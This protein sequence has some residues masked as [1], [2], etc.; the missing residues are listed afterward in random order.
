MQDARLLDVAVFQFPQGYRFKDKDE[1][2]NYYGRIKIRKGSTQDP[3]ANLQQDGSEPQRLSDE[4]KKLLNDALRKIADMGL[5]TLDEIRNNPAK[6]L[7]LMEAFKKAKQ[8]VT[9]AA[10]RAIPV[11]DPDTGQMTAFDQF[12]RKAV[13][14]M[15]LGPVGGIFKDDPIAATYM[16]VFDKTFFLEKAPLVKTSTG[17]YVSLAEAVRS[18]I[19]QGDS[20][21]TLK[22][23]VD[24]LTTAYADGKQG[25][26]LFALKEVV[27]AVSQ[28]NEA[29]AGDAPEPDSTYGNATI[30][31]DL[32]NGITLELVKILSGS[33]YMGSESTE[34]GRTN[35]EGPMRRVQITKDFYMGKYEVT[36]DQYMAVMGMNPSHS[37]GRNLPVESVSWN[38]VM[39]FCKR[40]T[41]ETGR[42]CRLPSEA[43]WEYAC[44]AGTETRFYWGDDTSYSQ[45]SDYAWYVSNSGGRMHSVG[46]KK[47]NKWGLYDMSGNVHEW[48]ADRF[49]WYKDATM[50]DP[51]GPSSGA[52]R[53]FRGGSWSSTEDSRSAYRHVHSPDS[54]SYNMG[55]RVALD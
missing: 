3:A 5:P 32:G 20:S 26:V 18:G 48:C 16:M 23:A 50:V 8:D 22:K 27:S 25:T 40:L 2:Y 37:S 41:A 4:E 7:D 33:F 55:F 45:I 39:A 35:R 42:S 28:A 14:G 36:Q 43:E 47:P 54:R 6:L 34:K 53:V 21:D 49:G 11:K 38:D 10:I 46:Q 19:G 44:R 15:D 13:A 24:G 30:T 17:E 29:M 1:V 9:I 52:D 51:K 31:L 12:A